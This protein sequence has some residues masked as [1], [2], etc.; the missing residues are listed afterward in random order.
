M[1]FAHGDFTADLLVKNL[2]RQFTDK[3]KES[4]LQHF[5]AK[6]VISMGSRGKMVRLFYILK[7]KKEI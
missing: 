7:Q 4:L 3:D 1:A 5:G 2:P 6:H